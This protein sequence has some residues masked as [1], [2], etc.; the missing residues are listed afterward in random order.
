VNIV[1][2]GILLALFGWPCVIASVLTT[3]I[4]SG[5]RSSLTQFAIC[6][7]RY[8]SHDTIEDSRNVWWSRY[9]QWAKVHNITM[10]FR[11]PHGMVCNGSS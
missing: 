7:C 5:A 6:D 11:N 3:F 4:V 9:W 2:R 8:R 1:Y 10:L